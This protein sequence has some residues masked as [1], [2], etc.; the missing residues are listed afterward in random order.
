MEAAEKS[1]KLLAV[2]QQSR[3]A[4]YYRQVKKVV[5]SGVLGRIVQVSIAFNGF[6]RRWDW[7][8]I[9]DFYV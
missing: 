4:P 7:Q 5:D 2:Y 9:Q 1:G 8:C 6:A 3:F